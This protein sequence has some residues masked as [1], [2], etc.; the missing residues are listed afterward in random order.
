M[1]TFSIEL[2]DAGRAE[3]F[4]GITSFVAEDASGSFGIRAGHARFM[5]L[6]ELGLA[7]FRGA[8]G[9]WRYLAL[10]GALLYFVDNA[11]HITTRHYLLDTDYGRISRALEERMAAEERDFR[12]VKES[13]RRMEEA[14]L[15]RI[16]ELR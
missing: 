8:A 2:R 9:P 7:R 10:P 16:W 1:K 6:L 11:L 12:A 13:L 5:T 3:R 14:L 15:R 4:E